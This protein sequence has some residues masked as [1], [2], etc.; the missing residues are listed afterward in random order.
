MKLR[1]RLIIISMILLWN[2]YWNNTIYV[3]ESE[4]PSFKLEI[5]VDNLILLNPSKESED[6]RGIK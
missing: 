4:I 2:F 6:E 1:L 5:G 3:D